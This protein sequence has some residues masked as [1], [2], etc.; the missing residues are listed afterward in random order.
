MCCLILEVDRIVQA[1]VHSLQL[2]PRE[3][4]KDIS[5]S[6]TDIVMTFPLISM[7]V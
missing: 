1:S 4:R 2:I 5:I 6:G 3:E 7:E